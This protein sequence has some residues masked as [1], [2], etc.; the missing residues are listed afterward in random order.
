M[1]V[2]EVEA[3]EE[4]HKSTVVDNNREP[5]LYLSRAVRMSSGAADSRNAESNNDTE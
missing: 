4:Q 1:D 5:F 3:G 2:N